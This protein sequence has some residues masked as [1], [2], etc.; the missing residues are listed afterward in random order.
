MSPFCAGICGQGLIGFDRVQGRQEF[1]PFETNYL[2]MLIALT[3][4]FVGGW[5]LGIIGWM[6]PADKLP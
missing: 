4:S 5:F 6:D 1:G 3:A 2:M